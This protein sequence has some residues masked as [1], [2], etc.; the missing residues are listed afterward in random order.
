MMK[1]IISLRNGIEKTTPEAGA[2]QLEI[3]IFQ[4]QIMMN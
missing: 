2:M 3:N 1:I 4:R